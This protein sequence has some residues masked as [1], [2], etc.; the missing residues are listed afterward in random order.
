VVVVDAGP[1]DGATVTV[2]V[3]E[4]H[5]DSAAA[6]ADSAA[7]QATGASRPRRLIG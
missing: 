5:A 6:H 1:G 2:F 7:T 4:P 3:P